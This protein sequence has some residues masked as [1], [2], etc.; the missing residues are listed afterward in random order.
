MIVEDS[1]GTLRGSLVSC[2]DLEH[3]EPSKN[4][5]EF[6]ENTALSR[7]FQKLDIY[8]HRVRG[9]FIAGFSRV[10]SLCE[11]RGHLD[12]PVDNTTRR[13]NHETQ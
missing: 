13:L 10:S 5:T 8:I 2:I 6:P 9:R 11:G 7:T 4:K 1:D 12:I 3:N